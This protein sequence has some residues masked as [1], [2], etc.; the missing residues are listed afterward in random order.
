MS[1][2]ITKGSGNVFADLGFEDA[3]EYKAKANLAMEVIEII[4]RRKLTQKEAAILIGSKQPDI[5]KLKS[6]NLKGFTIDRLLSFLLKLDRNI[7]I[8]IS[9]PRAKSRQGVLETVAA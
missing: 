2:D 3:T 7:Q 8:H 9:K 5:S 4:E 1:T 6:G